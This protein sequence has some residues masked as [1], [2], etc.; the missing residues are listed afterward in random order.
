MITYNQSDLLKDRELSYVPPHF[1]QIELDEDVHL[2]VDHSNTIDWIRGK[3]AGRFS[4]NRLTKIDKSNKLGYKWIV[5]FE[6]HKE[7]TY[8]L[9]A[10]PYIRR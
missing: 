4:I 1:Q 7:T 6:D 2:W 5:S 8:F 10:C 9:L 3:L